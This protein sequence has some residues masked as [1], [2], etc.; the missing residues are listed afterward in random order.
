[1]TNPLDSPSCSS[2]SQVLG[3]KEIMYVAFVFLVMTVHLDTSAL[4]SLCY[5]L[6]MTA[7]LSFLPIST[8]P[9]TENPAL[10]N[11]HSLLSKYCI[12]GHFS[13]LGDLW[14]LNIIKGLSSNIMLTTALYYNTTFYVF[15]EHISYVQIR[16]II[17]IIILSVSR[18]QN[19]KESW[20]PCWRLTK[21]LLASWVITTWQ[22]KDKCLD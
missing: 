8:L 5:H 21:D 4:P 16:Y 22:W 1:M 3:I 19:Y 6:Q 12:L 11:T 10:S 18:R 9:V 17:I 7:I 20:E 14:G 15:V 13:T 2:I